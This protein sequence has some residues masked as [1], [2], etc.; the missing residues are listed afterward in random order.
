MMT[1]GG[2]FKSR[3]IKAVGE[4]VT[5]KCTEAAND[6]VLGEVFIDSI[7]ERIK[8]KQIGK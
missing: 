5:K 2:E 3:T 4:D 7:V 1:I 6:I 8:K